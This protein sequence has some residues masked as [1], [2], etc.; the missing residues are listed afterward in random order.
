MNKKA[1]KGVFGFSL[2]VV[3]FVLILVL[4]AIIEP[5]KESLDDTRDTTSLNCP[6]T[7]NFNQT[8]YEVKMNMKARTIINYGIPDGLLKTVITRKMGVN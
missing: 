3:A 7:T 8:D 1:Q 6:G 4:L 2:V 5:F